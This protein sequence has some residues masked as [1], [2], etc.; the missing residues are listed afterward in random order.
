M[1]QEVQQ[2]DLNKWSK[3]QA[4]QKLQRQ[5]DYMHQIDPAS[6]MV[7]IL[8]GQEHQ[9]KLNIVFPGGL[10]TLPEQQLNLEMI[11]GM[12]LCPGPVGIGY[13]TPFP[14]IPAYPISCFDMNVLR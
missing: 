11:L 10:A 7:C 13:G 1:M 4:A 5:L 8:H 9:F 14:E 6:Q 3:K 2:R 12:V